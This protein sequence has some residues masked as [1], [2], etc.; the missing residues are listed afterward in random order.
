M[1]EI[2][3]NIIIRYNKINEYLNSQAEIKS[4]LEES[5]NINREI[6]KLRN[7]IKSKECLNY[8]K[9]KYEDKI[10]DLINRQNFVLK[11]VDEDLKPKI[12]WIEK[13]DENFLI[14][15]KPYNGTLDFSKDADLEDVCIILMENISKLADRINDLELENQELKN[16]M[17]YLEY[18][19]NKSSECNSDDYDF[20][21]CDDD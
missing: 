19:I 3:A 9:Q 18:Q 21:A 2:N 6:S 15:G 11:R 1:K 14:D 8:E 10:K 17:N 13:G 12:L 5:L 7:L 20:D 16:K 4:L